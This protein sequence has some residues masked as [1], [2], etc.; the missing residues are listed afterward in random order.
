[1]IGA[2][3]GGSSLFGSLQPQTNIGL[4]SEM[5]PTTLAQ[6]IASAIAL[7]GRYPERL[8]IDDI[9]AI[10]GQ[11]EIQV[12]SGEICLD[13]VLQRFERYS[14]SSIQCVTVLLD[15]FKYLWLVGSLA[16]YRSYIYRV[17]GMFTPLIIKPAA[18]YF[19]FYRPLSYSLWR[20]RVES[21][22]SPSH[23]LAPAPG[24]NPTTDRGPSR[25]QKIV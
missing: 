19:Y 18:F 25:L 12:I 20:T 24:A 21:P 3:G 9:Q 17:S 4:F 10:C 6:D 15:S 11:S 7:P 14:W 1:M 2:L 23:R 16:A 22:P 5:S 13:L 8:P